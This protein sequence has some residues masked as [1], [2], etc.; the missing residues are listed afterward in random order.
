M[1]CFVSSIDIGN[2]HN[3][4]LTFDRYF[5]FMLLA[6][7]NPVISSLRGLQQAADLKRVGKKLGMRTLSR[8]G[9]YSR[10]DST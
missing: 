6:F 3:R 1:D 2:H 10:I 9:F 8:S 5:T 4:K 7:Y